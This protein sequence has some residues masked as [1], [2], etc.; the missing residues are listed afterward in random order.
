M[1]ERIILLLQRKTCLIIFLLIINSVYGVCLG[2]NSENTSDIARQYLEKALNI[3]QE[4]SLHKNKVDWK[5]L[6][7]KTFAKAK[8]AKKTSDTWEAIRF[9]LKEI[10]DN[11][12][13]LQ[14]STQELRDREKVKNGMKSEETKE[15]KSLSPFHK[16]RQAETFTHKIAN[17]IVSRLVVPAHG[18]Q[19]DLY[20][21]KL[22]E[23]IAEADKQNPCGWIIDLRGNGGGNV[24]PMLAG[25]G[26]LL[27]TSKAVFA[28]NADGGKITFFY[29]N[30]Q[31]GL[32]EPDKQEKIITKIEGMA[33]KVRT[34]KPIAILIDRGTGSSGE[35]IAIAFRGQANT[36]FF[37]ENT[38]GAST[39]TRGFKL[40]DGANIVLATGVDADRN[41]KVYP[42]GVEPDEKI[43]I[44]G[45]FLPAN[46]DPVIHAALGWIGENFN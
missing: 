3:M 1:G 43:P 14:L 19:K 7:K 17:C 11:H 8:G 38:Y 36:R 18:S 29:L 20:S 25:I 41:G 32:I 4:N 23:F 15:K 10:G 35:L 31:A 2:Q 40:S 39:S 44:G 34:R 37:G 27:D 16:R 42:N 26:A 46:N 45:K 30:G 12:S 24:F 9:A 21:K 13:F 6:R 5:T 33:Y 28:L 22:N